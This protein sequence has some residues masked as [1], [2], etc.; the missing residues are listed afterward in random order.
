MW[1]CWGNKV[2]GEDKKKNPVL[3]FLL[4]S[5]KLMW[6]LLG[7]CLINITL[8][9]LINWLMDVTLL[10]GLQASVT[11]VSIWIKNY[12]SSQPAWEMKK[13]QWPHFPF[14]L[15]Y[16]FP[17]SLHK[18]IL[19]SNCA[20]TW[21]AIVWQRLETLDKQHSNSFFSPI[22][23]IFCKWLNSKRRG[24][25]HSLLFSIHGKDPEKHLPLFNCHSYHR[26]QTRE[27]RVYMIPKG[28][29]L[30]QNLQDVHTWLKK[31]QNHF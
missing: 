11:W 15:I 30:F 2:D 7:F 18:E 17:S 27:V 19:G 29:L 4:A 22:R 31:K 8:H 10:Q 16:C 24:A 28:I 14:R 21:T 3:V 26:S 9:S 5:F 25:F 6:P 1:W 23:C 13:Q 12:R 20:P